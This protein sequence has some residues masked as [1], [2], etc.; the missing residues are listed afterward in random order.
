MT[1]STSPVIW[2]VC[3]GEVNVR[4]MA[5]R[6]EPASLVFW[7]ASSSVGSASPGVAACCAGAFAQPE[8]RNA[9]KPSETRSFLMRIHRTAE[10]DT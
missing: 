9:T 3:C 5:I 1:Y 6:P 7:I 4:S 8:T 2:T 10:P